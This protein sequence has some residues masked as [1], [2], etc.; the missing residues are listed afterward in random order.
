MSVRSKD[1]IPFG[2][3]FSGVRLTLHSNR[4]ADIEG[5]RG[6]VEYCSDSIKINAGRFIIAFK[7]RNLRIKCMSESELI[8]E[9]F[10]LSIEYIL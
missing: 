4:E 8:I 10:I 2:E 1:N 7:G 3:N 6:I 5:S 9:G